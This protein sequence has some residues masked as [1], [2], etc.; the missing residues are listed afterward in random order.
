[1]APVA[2][3][4]DAATDDRARAS[5]DDDVEDDD[6]VFDVL[7]RARPGMLARATRFN[8]RARM[9][10]DASLARSSPHVLERGLGRPRTGV[11]RWETMELVLRV[12]GARART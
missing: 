9:S 3:L 12:R 10:V 11:K 6:D 1:M 8:I 7:A 4:A 5:A 2:S